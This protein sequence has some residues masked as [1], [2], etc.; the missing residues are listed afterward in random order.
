[1]RVRGFKEMFWYEFL[2]TLF[3]KLF[4]CL[5]TQEEPSKSDPQAFLIKEYEGGRAIP[6]IRVSR[7]R[8]Y[9]LLKEVL[10][11]REVPLG[12]KDYPGYSA[13]EIVAGLYNYV[14]ATQADRAGD[15]FR[16]GKAFFKI[17]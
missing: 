1:M 9:H 12:T 13:A 3:P 2:R 5:E 8:Y 10:E 11:S 15:A 6:F 17:A 16:K 4:L 7:A 14:E